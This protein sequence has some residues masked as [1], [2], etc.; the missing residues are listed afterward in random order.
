MSLLKEQWN[1]L[2]AFVLTLIAILAGFAD[3]P[4]SSEA[5]LYGAT[6]FNLFGRL[7]VAVILALLVAFSY[8]YNRKQHAK[9]WGILFLFFLV[10]AISMHFVYNKHRGEH[11][12]DFT[13][14]GGVYVVKG[15]HMISSMKSLKEQMEKNRGAEMDETSFFGENHAAGDV[16]GARAASL[17]WPGIEV[18]ANARHLALLHLMVVALYCMVAAAAIQ[19]LYCK[20]RK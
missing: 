13:K 2:L 9:G 14:F 3:M 15:D 10:A 16:T 19:F 1:V 11:T 20:G 18:R 6:S 4:A 5:A 8:R 17:I 12:L 7:S